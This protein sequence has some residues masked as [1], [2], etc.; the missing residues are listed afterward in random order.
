M[1]FKRPR[2][3]KQLLRK[4]VNTKGPGEDLMGHQEML[5]AGDAGHE[6]C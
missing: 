6:E 5:M 4:F 1:E 3:S 2:G